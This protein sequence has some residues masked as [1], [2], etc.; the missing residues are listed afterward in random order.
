[1]IHKYY[2]RADYCC[3]SLAEVV[4]KIFAAQR[5]GKIGGANTLFFATHQYCFRVDKIA[6]YGLRWCMQR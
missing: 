6:R 3:E 4:C 2:F 1:M 5:Y